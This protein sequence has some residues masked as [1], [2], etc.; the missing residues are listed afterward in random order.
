MKKTNANK[1]SPARRKPLM[2][3]ANDQTPAQFYIAEAAKIELQAAESPAEGKPAVRRFSMTAYTGGVMQLSGYYWPVVVDLQGV[4]VNSQA[5]PI[6]LA[7]DTNRILGHS[8]KIEVSSQ[9]IRV[10]GLLSGVGEDVER[11]IATADNGFPWQASIGAQ[12]IQMEFVPAGN[13]VKVN[14]RNLDGPLYV[15]RKTSLREISFAALGADDNSSASIAA[16]SPSIITEPSMTFSQWLQANGWDEKTLTETQ[17]PLL[18]AAYDV[19]I[20]A[21]N[22]PPTNP[23]ADPPANPPPVPTTIDASAL[24]Q[25]IRTIAADES[26]RVEAIR[27]ICASYNSPKIKITA[28]GAETEISLEAHAIREGWDRDRTELHAMRATRPRGPAIHVAPDLPTDGLVIEAALCMTAGLPTLQKVFKPETLE[29]ADRHYRGF[30]LQQLLVQAA[31]M[32]GYIARPGEQIHQGNLREILR[33]ALP[34]I[35]IVA[36][37]SMSLPG[38][39]SNVANKELLAGYMEENEEWR[40]I[41]VVKTVT[42][43]KTVTSYRMLDNFEYEEVGPMGEIKHGSTG[44][45]SYTR[46]ADTYAKMFA[47]TRTDI[48]NDD[49]GAFDDLRQRLGRGAKKKFN[50]LFWAKFLNNSSFFTAG[51]GNYIVG[52]TTNLLLDGIGLE[53]GVTAFRKL[54]SPAAD[55]AKKV[56]NRVGGRPDRLLVPPELEFTA[57][58]LYVS[59]N[60][61]T[62]GASTKDSVP[63]ANIHANKYRPIVVDWLSDPEFSGYSATA[64]YL[65]RNPLDMAPVSVSFLN[66]VQVPTVETADADFNTLGVQFRGYHD[67]GVDLAEYLAGVKSKGAA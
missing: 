58:R 17:L 29:A 42:D 36:A 50:N 52:A 46:K 12:P 28:N 3:L 64:W 45:E 21:T 23:Q 19:A 10:S 37:S 49:M 2:I 11:V 39:L 25:Q 34:P 38:I 57:D 65:F 9:R 26:S 20:K 67:F 5:R 15:A 13:K 53:Q 61:N 32:N 66:G 55:G 62:G 30:G 24:Q 59:S 43:F 47:L 27:S 14:G 60:V 33:C 35:G 54:K 63:N 6:L 16:T 22:P 41:A 48:I 56:G 4:Q 8:D 51:R 40:E 31:V 18:R 44:E 7:H 1:T